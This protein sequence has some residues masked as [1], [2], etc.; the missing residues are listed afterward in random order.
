MVYLQNK[1]EKELELQKEEL[2]MKKQEM[3]QQK[4][5]LKDEKQNQL[6]ITQNTENV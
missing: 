1:A 3:E 4:E 5:L 2:Q 6:L